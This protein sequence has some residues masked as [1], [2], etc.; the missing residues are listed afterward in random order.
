[1]GNIE[2]YL[3]RVNKECSLTLLEDLYEL[4]GFIPNDD[5]RSLCAK[6]HL[7]INRWFAVINSDL[8]FSVDD[9]G[10]R[11]CIGG[12]FHAQD[13]R[14]YLDFLNNLDRLISN[15]KGTDLALRICNDDYRKAINTVLL[16]YFKFHTL[17]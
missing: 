10:N 16:K 14:D 3:K 8:R 6:Y 9:D 12:Y 4:Y 17:N 15:L 1:M 13:S 11:R 5:L 2:A 7:G